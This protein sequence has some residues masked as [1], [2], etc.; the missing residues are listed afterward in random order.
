M[1][2]GDEIIVEVR[3]NLMGMLVWRPATTLH[4]GRLVEPF[5]WSN[6]DDICMTAGD[7]S[8]FI[9]Q[10]A[11]HNI[12]SIATVGSTDSTP[13]TVTAP[14]RLDHEW[15]VDGSKGAKYVVSHRVG[16]WSCTCPAGAHNRACK[17]VAAV[18]S[19]ANTY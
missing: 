2:I 6:P 15:I 19:Q 11:R 5:P 9:R 13:S 12:V 3:N 10:I 14:A 4:R 1:Q 8:A 18:K 7:G 17:H 16:H